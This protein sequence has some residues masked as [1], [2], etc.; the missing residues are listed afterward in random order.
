MKK[1]DVAVIGGGII[2]SSIAY[3]LARSNQVGSVAVIEPDPTYRLAATPQGAGG[4]G[5]YSVYLRISGCL[6]IQIDFTLI[7]PRL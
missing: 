6:V 1:F 7:F 5:K 3:F 2:G 4:C